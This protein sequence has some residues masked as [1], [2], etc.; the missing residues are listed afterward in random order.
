MQKKPYYDDI[1]RELKKT[2]EEL[3]DVYRPKSDDEHRTLLSIYSSDEAIWNFQKT[4]YAELTAKVNQ[5][6]HAIPTCKFD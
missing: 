4:R 3:G 6:L 1:E 2:L 5:L